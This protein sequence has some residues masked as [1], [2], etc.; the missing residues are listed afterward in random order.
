MIVLFE[1]KKLNLNPEHLPLGRNSIILL[2]LRQSVAPCLEHSESVNVGL[3][4]INENFLVSPLAPLL[5]FHP[6]QT[7]VLQ[8][9]SST[10]CVALSVP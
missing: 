4:G 6:S 9:A 7:A 5:C 8:A 3:Y 1:E 2:A 10:A